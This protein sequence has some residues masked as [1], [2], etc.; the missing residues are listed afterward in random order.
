MSELKDTIVGLLLKIAPEVDAA[1][2]KPDVDL[3]DQLDID[4][5]D[6]LNFV[7]AMAKQFGLE[8]PEKDY[9]RLT[10]LDDCVAYVQSHR[11]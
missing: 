2:I 1:E 9:P 4:S 6:H 7:I 11:H 3:R 10:T 5:M 8:I